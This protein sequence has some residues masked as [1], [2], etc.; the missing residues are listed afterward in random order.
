MNRTKIIGI[1]SLATLLTALIVPPASACGGYE[2]VGDPGA[3]RILF[4]LSGTHG[5][6]GFLGSGVQRFLLD[7]GLARRLPARTALVLVHAV[8]PFGFAWRRRNDHALRRD[9]V[10]PPG[11]RAQQK[12]IADAA[13]ENHLFV[14]FSD[15]SFR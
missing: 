1:M 3:T 14:Q 7:E 10:D 11:C 8:N 15:A 6:E 4:L 9:V 5:I 13:L 12:A 2:R